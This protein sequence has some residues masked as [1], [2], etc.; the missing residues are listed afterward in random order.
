MV[1]N[2]E[3]LTRKVIPFFQRNPLLLSKQDDFTKFSAIVIALGRG[4]HRTKEGLA[5]LL[6]IVFSVN[7]GGRYR[8][9]SLGEILSGLESSETIRR[10]SRSGDEDIVRA[11]W[12]HAESGRN[13]RTLESAGNADR[14]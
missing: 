11:A 14:E 6:E 13:D 8:R 9:A 1:R 12:R 5:G 7:G 2:C 4:E 10:T 3:D